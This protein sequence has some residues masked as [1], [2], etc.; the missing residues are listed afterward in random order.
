M[1]IWTL[2]RTHTHANLYPFHGYRFT[3]VLW[4]AG[5]PWGFHRFCYS[6]LP[7]VL[8]TIVMLHTAI[9]VNLLGDIQLQHVKLLL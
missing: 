3:W 2:T 7:L 6:V 5:N 4:V 1:G 8:T 9:A